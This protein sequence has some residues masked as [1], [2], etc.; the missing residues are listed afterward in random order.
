MPITY[1]IDRDAKLIRA[2][3]IGD[4]NVTEMLDCISSAVT[5]AGE[6]GYGVLSDHT[7]IVSPATREQVEKIVARLTSMRA[8]L[9]NSKWAV[10]VSSPASFGM[11]RMLGTLAESI[12]IHVRAFAD[13]E[14]AERWMREP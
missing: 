10:V 14:A 7:L 2:D 11:M 13:M 4:V 9:A 8:Q 3:V 6:P 1:R 12:P 5:E